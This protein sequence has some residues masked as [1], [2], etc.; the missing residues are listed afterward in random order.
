[1]T[2][3]ST[4]PFLSRPPFSSYHMSP[5]EKTNSFSKLAAALPKTPPL[6]DVQDDD[7]EENQFHH[8]KNNN[9]KLMEINKVINVHIYI[10]IVTII[11]LINKN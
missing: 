4:S 7:D 8:N 5:I 9:N 1:M 2:T 11:E 3:S 10:E 6:T